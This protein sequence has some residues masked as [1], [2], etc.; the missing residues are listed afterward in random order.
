MLRMRRSWS[1][2][3]HATA[4]ARSYLNGHTGWF[5]LR[6][7]SDLPGRWR[8]PRCRGCA[9]GACPC[10]HDRTSE[11]PE[12]AKRRAAERKAF[13]DTEIIDG[14]FKLTL[15][16]EFQ[17]AGRSDRIRKFDGPVRVFIDNEPSPTAAAR[18]PR[19]S[20]TSS[21][22]IKISTSP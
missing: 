5:G 6:T 18:S 1:A 22:A 16:A 8:R 11:H 12:I 14:F 15:N 3:C 13:T 7:K 19:P 10:R 21:T 4:V 2:V 9:A 20:P 17:V